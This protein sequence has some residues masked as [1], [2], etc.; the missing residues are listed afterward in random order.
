VF[1]KKEPLFFPAVFLFL[2]SVDFQF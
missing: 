2:F 1:S